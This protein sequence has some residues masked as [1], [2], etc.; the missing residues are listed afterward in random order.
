[1]TRV[2]PF[3]RCFTRSTQVSATLLLRLILSGVYKK[4]NIIY[5]NPNFDI[6][7][8]CDRPLQQPIHTRKYSKTKIFSLPYDVCNTK[9]ECFQERR[10]ISCEA[11]S[12][13]NNFDNCGFSS[14]KK[15]PDLC[16]DHHKYNFKL[17]D[18]SYVHEVEFIKNGASTSNNTFEQLVVPQ[19]RSDG[20][21]VFT[22]NNT[23]HNFLL[24]NPIVEIDLNSESAYQNDIRG[25]FSNQN[26]SNHMDFSVKERLN[27]RYLEFVLKLKESQHMDLKFENYCTIYT[28]NG[29]PRYK[30]TKHVASIDRILQ[31]TC[32]IEKYIKES[33]EF[34]S[35]KSKGENASNDN[36]SDGI[37]SK[38]KKF[39]NGIEACENRM[40]NESSYWM[41]GDF[42][43]S[44]QTLKTLSA[45]RY[46]DDIQE[47][48]LVYIT[49]IDR[50]FDKSLFDPTKEINEIERDYDLYEGFEP[51]EQENI[52]RNENGKNIQSYFMI[53][54]GHK[55]CK[56]QT[57]CRAIPR[58]Y[59]Q[60]ATSQFQYYDNDNSNPDIEDQEM[61]KDELSIHNPYIS[62]FSNKEN[63]YVFKK[64]INRFSKNYKC[65]SKKVYFDNNRD[66][67]KNY[68]KIIENEIDE[69]S[70]KK[71][72]INP[73]HSDNIVEFEW[74][75]CLHR[76]SQKQLQRI[77]L[78]GH[79]IY[80]CLLLK[81][82]YATYL[83]SIDRIEDVVKA[84]IELFKKASL[85]SNLFFT[86]VF[87]YIALFYFLMSHLFLLTHSMYL[88]HFILQILIF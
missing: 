62:T 44:C 88:K 50:C 56:L 26:R 65:S 15:N 32:S 79:Y 31:A 10:K 42:F 45:H 60:E 83:L 16:V 49:Q 52:Y 67:T 24:P 48:K 40:F 25:L 39:L 18:G 2:D 46:Y 27:Y 85:V 71:L 29:F 68:M 82:N 77:P 11:L 75:L 14:F 66:F 78:E 47:R 19:M 84:R 35:S 33:L 38:L 6:E 7:C 81:I 5:T 69:S 80:Y 23:T 17:E 20:S 30:Q 28:M 61:A 63:I 64:Q 3:V 53:N 58:R 54:G 59:M 72:N 4:Q 74:P 73:Y 87:F 86:K 76:N 9:S 41:F 51:S 1:M 22:K 21:I 37:G 57:D 8:H 13:S 12:Q 36:T 43:N 34:K 55:N 70:D